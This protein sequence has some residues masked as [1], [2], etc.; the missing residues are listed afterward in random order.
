MD[1]S[2][3]ENEGHPAA[4]WQDQ[5]CIKRPKSVC[6]IMENMAPPDLRGGIPLGPFRRR[7]ADGGQRDDIRIRRSARPL[8]I[9]RRIMPCIDRYRSVVTRCA[10]RVH[11]ELFHHGWSIL[12]S[13]WEL[14][15]ILDVLVVAEVL[16]CA[17]CLVHAI[18]SHRRPA[19]LEGDNCG[20][21]VHEATDHGRN[22]AWTG[23]GLPAGPRAAVTCH[24]VQHAD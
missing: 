10:V 2:E 1:N 13:D 7:S 15:T 19:E 24:P 12:G 22:I 6:Q 3:N 21:D 23:N 14:V 16:R 8:Q 20:N 4:A 18:R 9:E 11:S 17:A 5:G